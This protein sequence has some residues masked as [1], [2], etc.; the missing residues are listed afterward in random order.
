ML[1]AHLA[2]IEKVCDL[3][4]MR[5]FSGLL[6]QLGRLDVLAGGVVVQDNGDLIFVKDL[7]KS[8]L[9]KLGN[10]HRSGDVIPQHHIQLGLNEL[11]YF[12]L[13]QSSVFGQYL[14]CHGHSHKIYLLAVVNDMVANRFEKECKLCYN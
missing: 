1:H 9:F 12:H 2:H 10:S 4:L 14:L 7:G 11:P 6:A 3:V 13:F 8:G 5:K